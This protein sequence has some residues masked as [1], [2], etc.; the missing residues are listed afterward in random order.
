MKWPERHTI[1]R[2]L[3]SQRKIPIVMRPPITFTTDPFLTSILNYLRCLAAPVRDLI[4]DC[5]HHILH[6]NADLTMR[7]SE[8]PEV[9]SL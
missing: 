6:P 7:N 2:Y 1:L 5:S 4:P 9:R 3:K 8:Q